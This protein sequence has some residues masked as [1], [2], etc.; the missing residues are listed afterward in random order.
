MH[1]WSHG[2]FLLPQKVCRTLA[3]CDQ[4]H[5]LQ[6]AVIILVDHLLDWPE[7]EQQIALRLPLDLVMTSVGSV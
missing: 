4:L 1:R 6:L 7:G 5:F 3:L 2:A